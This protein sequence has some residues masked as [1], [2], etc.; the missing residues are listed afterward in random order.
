MKL[1]E[2]SMSTPNQ[3]ACL[4]LLL[5]L[6]AMVWVAALPVELRSRLQ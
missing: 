5:T 1:K 6:G 4:P 2:I 3:K